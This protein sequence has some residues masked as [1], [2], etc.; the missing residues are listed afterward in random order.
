MD[1]LIRA[2][3]LDDAE[4]LWELRNDPVTRDNSFHSD[5]IAW[6]THLQWFKN[7]LTNPST[8]IYIGMQAENMPVGQVR[9]EKPT[10]SLAEVSLA[11]VA[12]ARGSGFGKAMLA[13]SLLLAKK[14]L[15]VSQFDAF[16]KLDN[17]SSLRLFT[18]CGFQLQQQQLIDGIECVK[19]TMDCPI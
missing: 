8:R 4:F 10:A 7:K 2:A 17:E 1:I 13:N 3:N 6:E 12:D 5:P 14:E 19:F 11:I 15:N 9:F 18:A 16:V